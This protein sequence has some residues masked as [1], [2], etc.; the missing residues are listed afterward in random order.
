MSSYVCVYTLNHYFRFP[1]HSQKEWLKSIGRS[2]TTFINYECIC[3]EHFK[4]E[5][6]EN[7]GI[8]RRLKASA[9][10]TLN[11]MLPCIDQDHDKDKLNVLK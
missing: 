5:D 10:P 2:E 9:L 11:L 6:F 4:L 8:R 3:S 1:K 7:V